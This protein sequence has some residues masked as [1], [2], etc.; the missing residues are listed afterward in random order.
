MVRCTGGCVTN[1][2][3][4]EREGYCGAFEVAKAAE[5]ELGHIVFEV[6]DLEVC[7]IDSTNAHGIVARIFGCDVA[8][9]R[10]CASKTHEGIVEVGHILGGAGTFLKH[11]ANITVRRRLDAEMNIPAFWCIREVTESYARVIERGNLHVRVTSA[12]Q[13]CC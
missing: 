13:R 4:I 8:V 7:C 1:T 2:G 12:A 6:I 11:D 10:K 3:A 5:L 9:A